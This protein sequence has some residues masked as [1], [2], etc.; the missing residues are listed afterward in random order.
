MAAGLY[1]KPIKI[2]VSSAK[3]PRKYNAA[4]VVA[5]S[6]YEYV[7]IIN[8]FEIHAL[9]RPCNHGPGD[10]SVSDSSVR[11]RPSDDPPRV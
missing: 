10:V 9:F 1:I 5:I 8:S 4:H 2:I 6:N 7:R 11:V 3:S